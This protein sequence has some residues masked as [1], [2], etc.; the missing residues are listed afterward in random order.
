MPGSGRDVREIPR[1]GYDS[2]TGDIEGRELEVSRPLHGAYA[3]DV[4][5]IA[6]GAYDLAVYFVDRAGTSHAPSEIMAARDLGYGVLKFFPAEI[7]G[8]QAA[9]SALAGP[10]GGMRFCPT[11]GVRESNLRTY[12]ALPNVAVVGGTWIAGKA[13]TAAGDWAA[14]TAR[15]RRAVAIARGEEEA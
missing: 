11:G 14:I 12:L 9:L 5:G 10:F 15:A 13:E 3:L 4:G 7:Y 2:G 1:A 6:A 8:G